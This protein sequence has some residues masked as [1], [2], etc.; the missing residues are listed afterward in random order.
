MCYAAVKYDQSIARDSKET[1]HNHPIQACFKG[2]AKKKP[3]SNEQ[4]MAMVD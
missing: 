1:E 4:T 3:G 2:A